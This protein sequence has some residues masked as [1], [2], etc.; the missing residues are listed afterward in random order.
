MNGVKGLTTTLR[1][2]QWLVWLLLFLLFVPNIFIAG[3]T[4]RSRGDDFR[5]FLIAGDR[6]LK[7][8]FLY[9]DSRV[10]TNVTWPPFFAVHIVPIVWIAR[11]SVP[12]AQIV[13]Y[14]L[15]TVLFGLTVAMWCR[16]ALDQPFGWFSGN[17]GLKL[18]DPQIYWPILFSGEF[19]LMHAVPLQ[20]NLVILFWV[21]AG[22]WLLY[23][24]NDLAAGAAFGLAAALK[25]LPVIILPYL[26]LKRRWRAAASM[27]LAGTALTALPAILRYGFP[28]FIQLMRS[29]IGLSLTGGYPVGSLNQSVYAMI[30]RWLAS[31]PFML[32]RMRLPA[33][34]AD[35]PG[36]IA[37]FWAVRILLGGCFGLLGWYV[38][39]RKTRFALD[40]ALL[41][42]MMM[43]FSPFAWWHYWVLLFP[44]FFILTQSSEPFA[45]RGV[46]IAFF[47]M[48]GL[49]VFG[50]IVHPVGGFVH[51]V[52]SNMTL[53]ALFLIILLF[54][55]MQK[56]PAYETVRRDPRLQ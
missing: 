1:L 15:S 4:A 16:I 33:P 13:W 2:K 45:R 14:L 30:A 28:T 23:R 5:G 7:G 50:Q 6:F 12:A 47:L 8:T 3:S 55:L 18:S 51:C 40:G 19:L 43:V 52:L 17:R 37:S 29:W 35:A 44:A 42:A 11:L 27:V 31:D 49:N 9:E 56:E 32:I 53:G 48:T 36:A 10:A 41:L 46:W 39:R 25:A 34:P 38:I 22:F 54:R 20:F 24:E 26:V 21:T